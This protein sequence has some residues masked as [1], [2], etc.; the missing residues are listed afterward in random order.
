MQLPLF[1]LAFLAVAALSAQDAASHGS[2]QWIKVHGKGLEGNL[3][4]DSPDR[5]VAVYLPP[6]YQ[7]S[8]DRH[9]PV[10]YL[11]HGFTD[12][13]DRWWGVKQHFINVPVVVDKALSAGVKEMIVVMPDAFTRYQGSMYSN[14][15]TTGNW[16]DYI[17]KELVAYIDAHYRTV[18]NRSGRG[19]SGHS[20]G[21]YGAIRIGMK[22]P[23]VFSSLYL[24]SPC[25]MAAGSSHANP[26]A[27]AVRNPAEVASMD[28]ATK[29]M[30]ASAAAWSPNPKNPPLFLDLPYKNGEPQPGIIAKWQANAPLAMI[31]QF[32][33]SLRHYK[34][35]GMDVGVKDQGIAATVATLNKILTSYGIVHTYET[36]DGNHIDHIAERLEKNALPFFSQNLK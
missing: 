28:F 22:H 27:E 13:V 6:S 9:Y 29:A 11:L 14:S 2:V 8:G 12:D 31:D 10:I 17:A 23:E 20:M 15:I 34:A 25:C 5:K 1:G 18:A 4:G 3:E 30:L 36:Y 21:G 33:P 26:K 32:I 35:I 7:A 19:L 24:M 16:E